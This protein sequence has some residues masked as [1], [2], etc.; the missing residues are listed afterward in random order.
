MDKYYSSSSCVDSLKD[1]KVYIIPKK[2]ASVKGSLKW[3]QTMEDFASNT[4]PYLEEYYKRENSES[5]FSQDKKWF[6]WR[7]EQR[8]EDRIETSITCSNVLHN[9]FNFAK[10]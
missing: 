10:T 1:T 4:L 5:G 6:G 8:R 3:K 2:N 7:V 9:L